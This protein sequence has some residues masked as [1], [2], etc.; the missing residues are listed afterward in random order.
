MWISNES[1][2]PAQTTSP[3]GSTAKQDQDNRVGAVKVRKFRYLIKSH[4]LMDP[5]RLDVKRTLP[6]FAN[7]QAV[8]P[9]ECSVKVTMQNPELTSQTLIF[10]SSAVVMIF[11]PSGEYTKA[12]IESK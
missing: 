6:R 12:F 1:R 7:S 10:P 4:A 5:S 2:E 3:L 11:C 9:L 8:T